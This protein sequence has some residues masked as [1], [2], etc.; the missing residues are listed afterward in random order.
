VN[1]AP[2]K[3]KFSQNDGWGLQSKNIYDM[4]YFNY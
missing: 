2:C 3:E 1:D 4:L